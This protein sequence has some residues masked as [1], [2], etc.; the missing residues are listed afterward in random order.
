MLNDIGTDLQLKFKN[1]I[2]VV[3]D[4]QGEEEMYRLKLL[5]N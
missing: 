1:V 5:G 2:S 3:E 4:V